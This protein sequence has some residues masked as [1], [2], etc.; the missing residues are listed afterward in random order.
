[1]R[2]RSVAVIPAA[3]LLCALVVRSSLFATLVERDP[4][5]AAALWPDHPDA[6]FA[7]GLATVGQSAIDGRPVDRATIEWMLAATSKAPLAVEPFLVRGVDAQLAGDEELAGRAFLGARRLDPRSIPARYFLADH[8]LRTGQVRSGLDEI[9]T[10]ARLVPHSN[11]KIAP[12][13]AAFAKLPDGARHVRAVLRDN[14][15]LEPVL[16]R[17]LSA[18][19]H[20]ADLVVAL[21]SGGR[22]AE[23]SGWQERLVR[24]LITAGQYLKAYDAWAR[25]AGRPA[26]EPLINAPFD[27]GGTPPPFGWKLVA[28]PEGVAETVG[29][30]QLHMLHY[31]RANLPLASRL[32]LLPS[33]SYRMTMKVSG[34]PASLK[35]FRWELRCL[36]PKGE[37]INFDLSATTAGGSLAQPFVVPS[38]CAAQQLDLTALAPDFPE[39]ADVTIS[40]FRISAGGDR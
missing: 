40:A 22:S 1:M 23:A 4:A 39:Q 32:L 33:G 3:A 36:P 6:I 5:K 29:E 34:S 13:L 37:L 14:P 16:L 10:L 26:H 19:V 7:S 25:F 8:F 28:G 24:E 35:R 2:L 21:W 17:N 18:D 15:E 27:G 20:N 9:A 38:A 12:Y 31:G 11:E 30:G